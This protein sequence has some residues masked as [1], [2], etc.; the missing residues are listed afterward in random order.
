MGSLR[1][2][3]AAV[4]ARGSVRGRQRLFVDV[5]G[6]VCRL[7]GISPRRAPACLRRYPVCGGNGNTS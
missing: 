5:S 1:G 4:S 7:S 6:G 3:V 2:G